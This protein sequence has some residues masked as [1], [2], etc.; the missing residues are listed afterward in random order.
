MKES[1]YHS[2]RYYSMKLRKI[3]VVGCI[4][5][6]AYSIVTCGSNGESKEVAPQQP[7]TSVGTS[8]ETTLDDVGNKIS[9]KFDDVVKVIKESSSR[10]AKRKA[11]ETVMPYLQPWQELNQDLQKEVKRFRIDYLD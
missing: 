2:I 9:N 8:I 6:T 5:Y 1:T 10:Y 4:A 7:E 11:E 3:A